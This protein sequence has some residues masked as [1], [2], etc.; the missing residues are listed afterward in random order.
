MKKVIN[1]INKSVYLP[2]ELVDK[3]AALAVELDR[4][5]NDTVKVL[6]TEAMAVLEESK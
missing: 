1:G 5:W 2:Q 3:I 6:L 4:S